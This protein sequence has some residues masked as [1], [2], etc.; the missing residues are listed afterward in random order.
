MKSEDL[1]TGK[2]AYDASGRQEQARATRARIRD[3]AKELFVDHGYAGTSIGAIAKAAGVAPQTIYGAFGSKAKLLG[4][5][6]EVTLAGDDEPIAVFDRPESQRV[7]AAATSGE[8]VTA[9]AASC[10][11]ILERTAELLHVGDLAAADEPEIAAMAAGGAEGRR[12]DM[13]RTVGALA[14]NGLLR[15]DV[16]ESDAVDHVWALTSPDL[17]RSFIHDRGWTPDRYEEWLRG[18]LG[19]VI[20]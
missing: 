8:A 4:E 3:A 7:T 2:R 15:A 19:L 6:I 20:G 11:A 13:S 14:S 18:A 12:I 1:S 17:Y 5:V 10:R 9:L 16:T